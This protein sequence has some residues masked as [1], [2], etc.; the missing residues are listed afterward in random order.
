[1][2]AEPLEKGV[3]Q[4]SVIFAVEDREGLKKDRLEDVED[5][6]EKNEEEGKEVQGR[7][8]SLPAVGKVGSTIGGLYCSVPHELVP[9]FSSE[10]ANPKKQGEVVC[11]KCGMSVCTRED[12]GDTQKHWKG[13]RGHE[14]CITK[15][16][17]IHTCPYYVFN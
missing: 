12:R 13:I 7:N 1:M 10:N 15:H 8:N 2:V 17:Y 14:K 3:I 4:F 11:T 16:I 9:I 6:E 5:D